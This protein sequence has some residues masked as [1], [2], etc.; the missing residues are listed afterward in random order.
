MITRGIILALLALLLIVGAV[1]ALSDSI[2][3]L[4]ISSG[5]GFTQNGKYS[6]HGT[7]GQPVAGVKGNG[8]YELNAGFWNRSVV[9]Y[10]IFLPSIL[11]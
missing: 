4:V 6:V 3:R 5:G 2:D 11:N 10:E 1:V 9:K 8:S 7:V